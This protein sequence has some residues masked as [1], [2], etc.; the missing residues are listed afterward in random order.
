M[1]QNMIETEDIRPP[2]VSSCRCPVIR[3]HPTVRSTYDVPVRKVQGHGLDSKADT[4]S[5][6][7]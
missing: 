4:R 6:C 7:F 5:S 3:F 2:A 1:W